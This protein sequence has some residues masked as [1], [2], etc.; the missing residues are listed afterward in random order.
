MP[1]I[2]GIFTFISILDTTSERLKARNFLICWYFIWY[3]SSL[4]FVLIWV[5]H[6]KKFYNLGTWSV[7]C[8]CDRFCS[9]HCFYIRK[10]KSLAL[11]VF[12]GVIIPIVR[13]FTLGIHLHSC[14]CH[15][16]ASMAEQSRPP[17]V[18]WG[19]YLLHTLCFYIHVFDCVIYCGF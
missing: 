17:F 10:R 2:V 18:N 12:N 6:K 8:N 13:S 11:H 1:T 16:H 3:I 9:I 14:S 5:D 15:L 4:N 7:I 19:L